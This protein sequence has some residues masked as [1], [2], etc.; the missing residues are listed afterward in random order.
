[1]LQAGI[2]MI[3]STWIWGHGRSWASL[4]ERTHHLSVFIRMCVPSRDRCGWPPVA[5]CGW[6]FLVTRLVSAGL[7]RRDFKLT[8]RKEVVMGKGFLLLLLLLFQRGAH[9]YI[10]LS[11]EQWS[12]AGRVLENSSPGEQKD[13]LEKRRE[14]RE[15]FPCFLG[16]GSLISSSGAETGLPWMCSGPSCFLSSGD[17]VNIWK[18][19]ELFNLNG[20][21]VWCL[22]Y[23]KKAIFFLKAQSGYYAEST[24]G[25]R[26]G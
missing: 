20:R 5:L 15:F 21:T 6:V 13:P 25:G 4:M 11:Q 2:W 22:M 16:K 10:H 19:T 9:T 24:L 12:R 26:G 14:R 1:M 23:L 7:R 3:P 17:D 18:H 8:L